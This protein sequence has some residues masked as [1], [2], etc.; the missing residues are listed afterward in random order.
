MQKK[1]YVTVLALLMTSPA[2]AWEMSASKLKPEQKECYAKSKRDETRAALQQAQA[3]LS[4]ATNIN[5]KK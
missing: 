4:S 5:G 1:I 3:K 2:F